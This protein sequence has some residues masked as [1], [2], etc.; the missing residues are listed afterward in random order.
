MTQGFF[1]PEELE[2]KIQI[3]FDFDEGPNCSKCGL[4]RQCDSP[5]MKYTGQGKLGILIVGEAAGATEDKEWGFLKYKEPTQFIGEAGQLLRQ[6]LKILKLDLDRDFWKTNAVACRPTSETGANRPPTATEIKNCKP[7]LLKTIEELNPKMIWL[8]GGVAVESMYKGRFSNVAINRWRKLCIPDRKTGAYI[9]PLFHP[10]YINRNSRDENLRAVFERDLK[11]AADQIRKPQFMFTDERDDVLCLFDFNEVIY[12][13]EGVLTLAKKKQIILGIDYETNTLKPQWPGAKV[14]T[15]SYCIDEKSVGFPY[16]YNDFFTP[17]QQM[18]IKS[19]WR[20]IVTDPNVACVAHNIKFE[21]SWTQIIFGV[22]PYKWEWDTM[23][24]SH[25]EDNRSSY[26]GLKFQSYIK[27]GLEPYGN[28]IEKFLK[29]KTGHFN[30][31]NKA[32]LD[33]LLLYN[34]L[35]T[36][37]TMKLCQKQQKFF[38]KHSDTKLMDAYRLFHDGTLALSDVQ[39]NGICIDEEYYKKHNIQLG[40]DIE[41]IKTKLR[42]SEEAELFKKETTKDLDYGSTKDLGKLF[43]DI[44]KLPVQTTSKDNY[45]V[46]ADALDTIKIPFVNDLLELRKLEKVRGTYFSQLLREVCNGKIYPFFSLNIPVSYRSSSQSPNFQNIPIRDPEIGPLIR[47]GIFPSKGRKLAELDYSSIEVRIAA[48]ETRDPI[49]I[50]EAT[51]DGADMHTDSAMGVWLLERDNVS[52]EIRRDTKQFTFGMFYGDYYRQQA[53]KLWKY[54]Y[55]KTKEGI[56]LKEH[57]GSK[58]ITTQNQF[59]NH[60]KQYEHEFWYTRFNIYRQWKEDTNTLYRKQ[61]YLETKIGFRFSSSMNSKQ[62][63]NYIIQGTAFH[64]LLHSLILINKK[65]KEEGW[66]TKLIFQIHD[67]LIFDLVPEEEEYVLKTCIYIMSEEMRI[68]HP[69]IDVSLP[70]DVE[71]TK[72][73]KPWSTKREIKI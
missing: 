12:N 32:P 53:E 22:T 8:F 64:L 17:Q 31:I 24:A 36:K 7:L 23:L 6:E 65:S 40:I 38:D 60:L 68:L 52:K 67:S 43:Y 66:K 26:T 30:S 47:A 15:I 2:D 70:V 49:L 51:S 46:D 33:K 4:F 72:I 28:E 35:D 57:L 41:N 5:K 62:A 11:W 29:T 19:L 27:F 42:T 21:N 34:G 44:L 56:T 39:S 48:V 73:N 18:K 16:Q 59:E 69:W 37:M 71:T 10:S 63:S 13:L 1:S 25:I 45:R 58:G 14:A 20:K 50:A 9:I 54:I 61:G 3:E 55:L